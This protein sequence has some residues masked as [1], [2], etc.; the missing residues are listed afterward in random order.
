MRIPH[1]P[2]LFFKQYLLIIS[3]GNFKISEVG[4]KGRFAI[5]LKRRVCFGLEEVLSKT[6][7]GYFESHRLTSSLV[8][9]CS[10]DSR[11]DLGVA[12]H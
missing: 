4:V 12:F 6:H 8:Q 11:R 1:L 10:R 2:P 3:L 7:Y 5:L 9:N